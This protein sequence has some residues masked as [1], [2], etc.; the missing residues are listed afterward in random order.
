MET[1]KRKSIDRIL[2][3]GSIAVVGASADTRKLGYMT[4]E[5]LIFSG[6][7][8]NIYPVNPR[9]GS[10]LDHDVYTRIE[11]LP[12][13]PD[14]MVV[15]IPAQA[16]P[17][18]LRKAAESGIAAALI[19]SAGF[20]DAGR[21]DLDEELRSIVDSTGIRIL[22]PNIQGVAYLP[23]KLCAMF[24]PIVKTPGPLTIISQSGSV[25]AALM[26]WAT[27]EGIGI[28]AAVNLGNQIDLRDADYLSYFAD[29]DRTGVIAVYLEGI[30]NGRDFLKALRLVAPKKPVVILKS[31]RSQAGRLSAA[32]H[33]GALAVNQAIF[34]SVCRQ[35]GIQSA[36][37][38][39]NL[40]LY[41]K[42]LALL[43]QPNGNR[44]LSISS[45][46]GLGTLTADEVENQ[47]LV[48]PKLSREFIQEL[49]K[50]DLS[51]LATLSNPLDLDEQE[52]AIFEEVAVV[53]DRYNQADI[54]LLNFG[55]PIWGGTKMVLELKRKLN[56]VLAVVYLGGGNEEIEAR[57]TLP[58]AGI[59]VFNSP[60]SAVKGIGTIVRRANYLGKIKSGCIKAK[61]VNY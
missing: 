26:E 16:V 60:E 3:A 30:K 37:N 39:E 38:L 55:D 34:E 43:K 17:G 44:L 12:E 7:Q 40:Y 58:A 27:N 2:K 32:S 8:G 5:T 54:I 53:A 42:S 61:P 33:T 35:Y 22:G 49:E 50:L 11:D 24:F 41:A 21:H 56:S 15:I 48:L 28:N 14:L 25:T 9:G 29:D 31:G 46:G 52:A 47:G 23:N 19:L 59:P 13:I 51:P 45:S 10:I 36:E 20:G 6:Y 57:K 1:D 18:L 4:L